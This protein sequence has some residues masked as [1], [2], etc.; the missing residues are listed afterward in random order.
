M[1]GA[2]FNTEPE[3]LSSLTGASYSATFAAVWGGFCSCG[4]MVG[5]FGAEEGLGGGGP[6]GGR[7]LGAEETPDTILAFSSLSSDVVLVCV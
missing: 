4:G 2:F 5:R 1:S 3:K 6:L 7:G